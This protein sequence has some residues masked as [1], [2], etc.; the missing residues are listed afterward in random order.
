MR[1]TIIGLT[2]IFGGSILFPLII[3]TLK[4]QLKKLFE[5]MFFHIFL[6]HLLHK[7]NEAYFCIILNISF[8]LFRNYT[9]YSRILTLVLQLHMDSM[10]RTI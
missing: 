1:I 4:I 2:T 5:Y 6:K 10:L 8:T 3:L 9:K 7:Q